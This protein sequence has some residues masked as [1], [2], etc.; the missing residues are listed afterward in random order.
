MAK[1][2]IPGRTGN[3]LVRASAKGK[4]AVANRGGFISEHVRTEKQARMLIEIQEGK[5]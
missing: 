5:R 4:L 2:L 3:K 1:K